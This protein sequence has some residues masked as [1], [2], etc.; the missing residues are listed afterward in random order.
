M[1]Q[2]DPRPWRELYRPGLD[3]SAVA[4]RSSL[5]EAWRERVTAA[6]TAFMKE[7]RGHDLHRV[8]QH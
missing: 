2:S 8:G 6:P 3:E 4:R 1:S 7:T 5:V